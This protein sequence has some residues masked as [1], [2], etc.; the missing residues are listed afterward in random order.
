MGISS[1]AKL[2]DYKTNENG[3]IFG[4]TKFPSSKTMKHDLV[5]IRYVWGEGGK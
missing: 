2:A 1:V 5:S 4:V 3:G